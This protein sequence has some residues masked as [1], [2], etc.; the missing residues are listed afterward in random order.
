ML[1]VEEI[2][3]IIDDDSSSEKKKMAAVGQKYYE[4]EHDILNY[5]LF[6]FNADGKLVED[7][8]R[9][10][11]RICHPFFT[12]LSDQLSSFMLSFTNYKVSVF[13]YTLFLRQPWGPHPGGKWAG[14]AFRA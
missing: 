10:N 13:C 2:K 1:S 5:R 3:R 6:Y 11:I 7:K 8:T 4:A 14:E 12:I 9:A